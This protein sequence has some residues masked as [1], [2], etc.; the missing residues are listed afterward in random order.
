MPAQLTT[1]PLNLVEPHPKLAFRFAYDVRGLADSIRAAADE[2]TPNGQLNPGRVVLEPDGKGYYV[3]VGVR[4]YKALKLLYDT[5]KDERFGSYTAYVDTGMNELQMF[6]KAKRENDEE[7]G[8]RQG[9]SVLEELF[10]ITLIRE[11]ISP[12]EIKD[13]WLK[14]LVDVAA[15]LDEQ[16]LRRLYEIEAATHSK[17]RLPHLEYLCRIGSEDDFILTAATTAA[18]NYAGSDMERAWEDRSSVLSL[19]WFRRSF[20]EIKQTEPG[21][22]GGGSI[23]RETTEKKP[24]AKKNAVK[25]MEVHEEEVILVPCPR[26]GRLHMVETKGEI[27]ATHVPE[28]PDGESRTE[29]AAS[30]SRVERACSK[31]GGR[32]FAFVEHLE[33]RKYAA[34]P[35]VSMKFKEPKKV[36]EAVDLRFDRKEDVWQIIAGDKVVGPLDFDGEARK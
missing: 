27:E 35:S 9:L 24:K 20:P 21:G 25:G 2:N 1:I 14:R 5:T 34:E 12:E 32:F 17:F 3:Y 28:D 6:V 22:N 23:Q 26:C 18:F 19:D 4:R 36:I 10:G 7:K 13:Q 33:G 30:V 29:V 11:A 8:E 31:C 16:K 15:K